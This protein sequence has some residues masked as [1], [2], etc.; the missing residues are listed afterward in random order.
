MILTRRDNLAALESANKFPIFEFP[1]QVKE[2]PDGRIYSIASKSVTH[3]TSSGSLSPYPSAQ[4]LTHMIM[5]RIGEMIKS[6]S[7]VSIVKIQDL[8]EIQGIRTKALG[9]EDLQSLNV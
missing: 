7:L 1:R 3:S 8:L 9:W 5:K 2:T 4:N 6:T